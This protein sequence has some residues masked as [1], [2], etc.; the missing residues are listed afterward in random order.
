MRGRSFPLLLLLTS[1]LLWGLAPAHAEPLLLQRIK[2]STTGSAEQVELKFSKVFREDPLINFDSGSMSLRLPHTRLD[3]SVPPL[4]SPAANPLIRTI[5]ATHSDSGDYVRVDLHFRPDR[6]LRGN[7]EITYSMDRLSLNLSHRPAAAELPLAESSR[8][9]EQAEQKIQE[10]NRFTSTFGRAENPEFEPLAG[11]ASSPVYADDD[12]VRT[13]L[14]LV[15]ALL[16]ILLLI[17]LLAWLYNRFFAGRFPISRGKVRIRLVST[18]HVAPRQK[19]VVLEING[20]QFACGVT[21]TSIS[22]ISAIP[23]GQVATV[24]EA[25]SLGADA[26]NT[27]RSRLDFLKALDTARRQSQEM[28]KQSDSQP[29]PESEPESA[30]KAEAAPVTGAEKPAE[31]SKRTARRKRYKPTLRPVPDAQAKGWQKDLR[32]NP[33]MEE[34]ASKLSERLKSLKP[35]K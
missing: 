19:V 27:D 21:P 17:Y 15:L 11:E 2:V 18:F 12:W 33:A 3:A 23:S 29:K 7:P 35:I 32:D 24:A 26:T 34:F 9:L 31:P 16:F 4:I 10:G 1:L 28:L 6:S 8:L 13:M 20:Q 25:G 22:L 5:R 30:S 14:S